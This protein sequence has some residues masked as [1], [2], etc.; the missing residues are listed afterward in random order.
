MHLP[1][2]ER[3]QI[4]GLLTSK[5]HDSYGRFIYGAARNRSVRRHEAMRRVRE[6]QRELVGAEP[7]L[8]E[9]LEAEMAWIRESL[10]LM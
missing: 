5:S 4:A 6:I 2:T 8:V 10:G 1:W 3:D 7:A 9:R